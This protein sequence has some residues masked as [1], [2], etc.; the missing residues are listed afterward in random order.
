MLQVSLTASMN[1][2][3]EFYDQNPEC[4]PVTN[5][6]REAML[7]EK[8]KPA[9]W[10]TQGDFEAPSHQEPERHYNGTSYSNVF[11][12]ILSFLLIKFRRFRWRI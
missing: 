11:L 7:A 2:Q 4:K 10:G 1:R 5:H 12:A 3:K 8:N 9:P 6:H